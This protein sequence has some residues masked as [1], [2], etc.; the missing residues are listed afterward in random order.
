MCCP[1]RFCLA[2]LPCCR[3]LVSCLR[4]ILVFP[5][6]I[7]PDALGADAFGPD[8]CC[9]R[10]RHRDK[11]CASMVMQGKTCAGFHMLS[12]GT[13]MGP[14]EP[15]ILLQF[16]VA[17]ACIPAVCA[18]DFACSNVYKSAGTSRK[19]NIFV[20]YLFPAVFV[21]VPCP[22]SSECAQHPV[23]L[24]SGCSVRCARGVL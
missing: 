14:S 16:H 17:G 11:V 19:N 2:V 21:F 18:L 23:R 15:E 7:C 10:S 8:F 5:G 4:C 9:V 6:A 3:H 22:F 24:T 1:V 20:I 12:H 13:G